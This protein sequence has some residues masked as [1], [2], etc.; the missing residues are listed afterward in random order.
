MSKGRR[1]EQRAVPILV[2]TAGSAAR[3]QLSLLVRKPMPNDAEGGDFVSPAE[4]GYNMPP[5]SA[6]PLSSVGLIMGRGATMNS[7]LLVFQGQ[8]HPRSAGRAGPHQAAR[9]LRRP[10]VAASSTS[11]PLS[12]AEA[13]GETADRIPATTAAV[14]ARPIAW[15][16][17]VADD[18][19]LVSRGAQ[20]EDEK[21][22]WTIG[23]GSLSQLC[24]ESV[25]RV[26][27]R[28]SSGQL[29][30][31]C[32]QS[33]GRMIRACPGGLRQPRLGDAELARQI[34]NGLNRRTCR[35]GSRPATSL[36][37][38]PTAPRS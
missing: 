32:L 7:R 29:H 3:A 33:P 2:D 13:T 1:H 21:V 34:C 17:F 20:F 37:T 27:C 30:S 36:S 23:A 19:S 22:Q 25:A 8:S 16:R 15:M 26:T 9:L 6:S 31:L 18:C 35:A 14:T 38:A 11:T 28:L 24:R 4:S 12:C 5:T 10:A